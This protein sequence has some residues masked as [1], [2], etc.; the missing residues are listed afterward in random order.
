M[1]I[2]EAKQYMRD[3]RIAIKKLKQDRMDISS[4]IS[5]REN[6]IREI[7]GKIFRGE[8]K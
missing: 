1:E 2:K 6:D 7:K 5:A 4:V 3:L 8:I